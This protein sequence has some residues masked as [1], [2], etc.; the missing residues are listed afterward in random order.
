MVSLFLLTIVCAQVKDNSLSGDIPDSICRIA[1]FDVSGN[2]FNCPL[3]T[4]CHNDVCHATTAK[5]CLGGC[6]Q[7]SPSPI[8]SPSPSA[9]PIPSPS[10][11]LT[12]RPPSPQSTGV[13]IP[14][15]PPAHLSSP[16][17]RTGDSSNTVLS[18]VVAIVLLFAIVVVIHLAWTEEQREKRREDER[19][20]KVIRCGCEK[21]MQRRLIYPSLQIS[22]FIFFFFFL[23][24]IRSVY[25]SVQLQT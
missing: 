3:P 11:H 2:A 4:C 12:P 15:P 21:V 18:L 13:P 24:S 7:I 9:P 25:L 14:L 17:T 1:T 20:G 22:Q 19:R 10:P 8:P 5:C 6:I 23:H 16:S